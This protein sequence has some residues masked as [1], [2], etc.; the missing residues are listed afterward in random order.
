MESILIHLID[1]SLLPRFC[2]GPEGTAAPLPGGSNTFSHRDPRDHCF[3][4][5]PELCESLSACDLQKMLLQVDHL[6]AQLRRGLEIELGC[7]L[8]HLLFNLCDEL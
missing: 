7:G 1:I 8:S 5:C 4:L 3:R 2:V 6:I